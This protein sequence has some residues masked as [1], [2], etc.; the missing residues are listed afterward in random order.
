MNRRNI[1]TLSATA[2]LGLAVLPNQIAAQ[3]GTLKQQLVGTWM[4]VSAETTAPNGTKEQPYGILMMD[5]GGHFAFILDKSNRPKLASGRTQST[6]QELAAALVGFAA[7]FGTWSVDEASKTV[8]YHRDGALN[9]NNEGT[10]LN[11]STSISGDELN[12][13]NGLV[14]RRAK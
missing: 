12:G 4:L 9:P 14:W 6:P 2:V 13:A 3:Q 1:F 10:D 5:A 8:T 7:Q 11:V